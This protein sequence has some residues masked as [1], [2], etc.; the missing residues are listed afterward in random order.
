MNTN[1]GCHCYEGYCEFWKAG[2]I[3]MC[4]T[5]QSVRF[6]SERV[7]TLA[8]ALASKKYL[9]SDSSNPKMFFGAEQKDGQPCQL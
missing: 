5:A 8:A 4:S 1:G 9:C 3:S 7:M 2:P 6:V